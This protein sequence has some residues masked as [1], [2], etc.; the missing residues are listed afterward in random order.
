[1]ESNDVPAGVADV[2]L[3]EAAPDSTERFRFWLLTQASPMGEVF[4][5]AAV[6][7]EC[8]PDPVGQLDFVSCAALLG[9]R[10]DAHKWRF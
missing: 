3:R 8:T 5:R 6:L 2:L 9:G 7:R 4:W 10:H 1:M